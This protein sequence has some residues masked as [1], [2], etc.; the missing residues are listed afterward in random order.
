M[1][2]FILF[3]MYRLSYSCHNLQTHSFSKNIFFYTTNVKHWDCVENNYFTTSTSAEDACH[4][5][6]APECSDVSNDV[7]SVCVSDSTGT[8]GTTSTNTSLEC[9]S[10]TS[11]S[12][13][14]RPAW[15]AHS[16]TQL[17]F[18]STKKKC[19]AKPQLAKPKQEE[20][21]K[22]IEDFKEIDIEVCGICLSEND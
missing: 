16:E 4:L 9:K 12:I 3:Y 21:A 1:C 15:N 7:G 17:W 6:S 2:P 13:K 22:C 5:S 11:L 20:M 19:K 10:I 8:E 14:K 18:H